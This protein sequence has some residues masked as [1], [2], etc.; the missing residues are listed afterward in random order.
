MTDRLDRVNEVIKEELSQALLHELDL[1]EGILVTV[2]KVDTTRTLEHSRIWIS[3]YPE[4]KAEETLEQINR[5]IYDIQQVLNKRLRMKP[6]P[7]IIFK[8]DKGGQA[9]GEVDEIVKKLYNK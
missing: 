2:I 7:K 8:L 3:I 1:E 9:V 5:Q 6:I 4:N